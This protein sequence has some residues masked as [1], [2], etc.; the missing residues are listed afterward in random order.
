MQ[1]FDLAVI[2]SGSGNSLIDRRFRD[3]DVALI[4]EHPEFGGTCLNRGCIPT[5]MFA[6]PA[7]LASSA[8]HAR[9]L[10]VDLELAGVDWPSVRDRVFG[11]VDPLMISGLAH[12]E[13]GSPHVTLF[14]EHASFVDPHTLQ[15]G[16]EQITADRIVLA[17]GSRAKT[18]DCPG[19]DDPTILAHVHTSDTIM[20]LPELPKSLVIVGGG[21]IAAEFAHIFSAFGT[22]VTIVQRSD[23]LLRRVDREV[24]ARF[25]ELMAKRVGIR[26]NQTVVALEPGDREGEIVVVT[27]D[28]NGVEYFYETECVLV[29]TGRVPNSDRL[30]LEAAGVWV[31]AS[32]AIS[33]DPTQVTTVPHIWALGDVANDYHLKHVANHEMRTVHHNLLHPENPV[34]SDHRYVPCAIFSDPQ[35]AMVGATEEQLIEWGTPYVKAVQPY[36]SVA[37]GWAMEDEGHFI[38]LLSDPTSG[39]LLGA[40]IIG[41]EASVL[42]QPLIQAMQF[43]LDVNK[44]AR[45]Q[46]W[47][48]PS[49]A[50]VVENALL[51]LVAQE[52]RPELGAS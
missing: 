24:G 44:M 16:D 22:Q 43:G 40:H 15:V 36:S 38:K 42:V 49:L 6:F 52:R 12:R 2:G 18:L 50:E 27:S 46:F 5:K 28:R 4:D 47:I 13:Q 20:R 34:R 23:V 14:R 31:T 3:W 45:G 25:S 8:A 1:H 35:I 10:G 26:K 51:G 19:M 32:G 9:R 21:Y 37:Y 17:A 39:H 7:D 11:R 33:V 29:A 30:N 41:P 48:H